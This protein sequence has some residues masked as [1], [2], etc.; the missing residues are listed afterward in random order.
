MPLERQL[1]RSAMAAGTLL[2]AA[3]AL[4]FLFLPTPGM[5]MAVS[6][7]FPLVLSLAG[8]G[9]AFGIFR[10][11]TP[12]HR[13]AIIWAA[14]GI[15]LLCWVLGEA[16]YFVDASIGS[17]EVIG[18]PAADFF[19]LAGYLPLVVA[20]A[21]PYFTLRASLP[22]WGRWLL[23]GILAAM[24]ILIIG[25]VIIPILSTP[26][27]GTP[28]V[29]EVV[30]AYP[31]GDLCLLSIAIALAVVYQ[32]GQVARSWRLI[33][34]GFQLFT[35]SDL[36]SSFGIWRG[37]YYPGGE[38]NLLSAVVD[39]L[40]L[41][42]YVSLDIGLL[43][44]FRLPDPGTGVILSAFI[45]QPG[46]DFLLVADQ[47]GRVVFID[48][49]LPSLL[50]LSSADEA[51]GKAY[52]PLFNLPRAFEDSAIRKA[53]KTGISDDYL[54]TLGL[55]QSKYRLRLV[56]SSDP[57]Q[58]LGFDILL[59]P[60]LKSPVPNTDRETFLLGQV[61]TQA[62]ERSRRTAGG[63]DALRVYFNTLIELLFILVSRAGG[64]GVGA[65]F[66]T[67]VNEKARAIHCGL[68][69]RHGRGTWKEQHTE[70]GRY[71]DLLEEAVRYADQVTSAATIGRKM[72][73]I[74][75]FMDPAIVR[76]A[77]E[78]RL[79]RTRGLKAETE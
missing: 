64:A 60:D 77:E 44:R 68:T 36:L 21:I 5:L 8:M 50:G 25:V 55:S 6:S 18:I 74:E 16:L 26:D 47:N 53:A 38:L 39:I 40:Y 24:W 63:E 49:A 15:G 35:I 4:V 54:I 71:R 61:A 11:Q 23:I 48:P 56:A 27:A 22:S 19:W 67:V 73:E 7:F 66:E 13:G 30:L 62:Q 76:V 79:R 20:V 58:S 14:M 41:A 28:A 70:P 31:I 72:A 17:P 78:H 29:M 69:L 1:L 37:L 32:G 3:A 42:A 43:L 45:P 33:S 9:L 46:K 12:D 57:D 65:A 2:I 75:A 59:H 52:G 51:I 34:Y 10:R